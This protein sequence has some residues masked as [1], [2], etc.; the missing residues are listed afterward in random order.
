MKKVT[1]KLSMSTIL[2]I[3]ERLEKEIIQ[4]SKRI[5]KLVKNCADNKNNSNLKVKDLVDLKER[6]E[7]Q[8]IEL[9][10]IIQ[11]GNLAKHKNGLLNGR[12]NFYYIYKLSNLVA[13]KKT[14]YNLDG[15]FSGSTLENVDCDIT[16]S[17]VLTKLRKTE[18]EIQTIEIKLSNFNH[19][20]KEKV[21]LDSDLNLIE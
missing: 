19:S 11:K 21:E 6:K 14:L 3:K 15:I 12:S 9:K 13:E 7:I 4:D 5:E 20:H 2:K 18:A 16:H 1:K 10:L 8:L 17:E